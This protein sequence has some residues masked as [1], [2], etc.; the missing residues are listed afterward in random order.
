MSVAPTEAARVFVLNRYNKVGFD[1]FPGIMPSTL[2]EAYAIQD[3]AIA[4]WNSPVVGWKVGRIIGE[5]ENRLGENRFLGP[6]FEED[7]WPL[8]TGAPMPFPKI[9]GGFAALE[10]ELVARIAAPGDRAD[11]T[12]QDCAGLV[13]AWHAG[14]EAAG[15][16]LA[17]INDLGPLASIAGFGNNMGLILGPQIAITDPDAVEATS[18]IGDTTFGPRAAGQLPGGALEAIA[19]A[20]NRLARMGETVP[21]GCLIST[22]AVTGV[23]VVEEGQA[24]RVEFAGHAVLECVVTAP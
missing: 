21:E 24:C 17:T 11:W 19:F 1:E 14:I 23:H 5:M 12:A 6:I 2:D 9:R 13:Q 15:S 22:G 7:V 16:P 4:E 3:A 10:A 8:E 18:T 20:L